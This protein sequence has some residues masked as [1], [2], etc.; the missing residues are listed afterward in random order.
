[1]GNVIDFDNVK[2]ELESKKFYF[3]LD[4]LILDIV[5]KTVTIE[6]LKYF[7]V[8]RDMEESMAEAIKNKYKG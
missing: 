4:R 3:E 8:V 5:S 7:N 2:H 6:E 1:M